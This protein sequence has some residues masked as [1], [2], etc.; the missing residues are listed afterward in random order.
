MNKGINKSIQLAAFAG[1]LCLCLASCSNPLASVLETKL[2]EVNDKALKSIQIKVATAETYSVFP[3]PLTF[4]PEVTEYTINGDS[5]IW[6][7]TASAVLDDLDAKLEWKA[8]SGSWTSM[9]SGT[10]TAAFDVNPGTTSITFRVTPQSGHDPRIYTVKLAVPEFGAGSPAV[11]TDPNP[12]GGGLFGNSVDIS[13]DGL[14]MAVGGDSRG[15]AEQK[16]VYIYSRTSIDDSWSRTA[17]ISLGG[18]Q[19]VSSIALSGDGSTFVIGDVPNDKA[20]VYR[21]SGGV[22]PASPDATLAPTVSNESFG[23]CASLSYNGSEIAVGAETANNLA[24][25]SQNGAVYVFSSTNWGT[26]SKILSPNTT[27]AA[28]QSKFGHAAAISGNGNVLVAGSPYYSTIVAGDGAVYIYKKD[29]NWPAGADYVPTIGGLVANANYGLGVDIN[30]DGSLVLAGA[31]GDSAGLA[32]LFSVTDNTAVGIIKPAN[33]TAGDCFGASVSLSSDGAHAAVGA[34]GYSGNSGKAYVYDTSA[35]SCV[36]SREYDN[37][38]PV[39]NDYF[40][41]SLSLSSGTAPCLSVG[42]KCAKYKTVSQQ[43]VV[44][45]FRP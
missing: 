8:G 39:A 30:Y 24:G 23:C 42:D 32:L 26:S 11:L 20:Y 31:P 44:Y 25:N 43:G 5:L 34:Y 40:G 38:H 36:L 37:P 27:V 9:V 18:T 2:G 33:G 17:T 12:L 35:S 28:N 29:T 7:A 6:S 1:L 14:T 19:A 15:Q 13:D 3:L 45:A 21:H 4:D 41:S 16:N 22:W 10:E